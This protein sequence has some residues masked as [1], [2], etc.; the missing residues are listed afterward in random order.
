[1]LDFILKIGKHETD[2]S[3]I[4]VQLAHS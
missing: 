1:L 3:T 2:I 4:E